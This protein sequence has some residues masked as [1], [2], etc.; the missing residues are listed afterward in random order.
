MTGWPSGWEMGF[1]EVLA[2]LSQRI[3]KEVDRLWPEETDPA[4]RAACLCEEAGEVSRA[5]TKRRHAQHNSRGLCKGLT[6]AQWTEELAIELAQT[7]GVILDIAH[8]EGI[9]LCA[10]LVECVEVLERREEGS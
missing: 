2:D 8:R 1:R 6:P 10:Y 5:I 3:V 9:D 7:M 4:Y